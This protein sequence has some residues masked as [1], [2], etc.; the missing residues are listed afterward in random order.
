[1]AHVEDRWKRDGR[2]GTGRRWRVRYAGPDG[3]ERSKSFDRKVDADRFRVAVEADVQRGTYTDPAA[4]KITLR[5]Y[6]AGWQAGYSADTSRGEHIASHLSLHILPTLGEAT[7]GQLAERPSMIRQWYA[8]LPL[9]ALSAG[10]VFITLSA[11]LAAAVDDGKITR[12]PCKAESVRLRTPPRRKIVPWTPAQ[13]AAIRAGMPERWRAIVDCGLGLGLRQGEAFGLRPEAV[14]FL[15]RIVH[16][17]RQVL[18]V[19]GRLWLAAPKEGRERDVPLGEPVAMALAAHMAAFRPREVTL[20]WNEPGS[21]R[22][23]EPVTVRLVFTGPRGQAINSS[24]FGSSW[25]PAR[26][27]A[28]I[29]EG[30]MHMLRH[31]YASV[32]LA[33]GVDI[34][35]LSE[36]LGHHDPGFT[37][38]VYAHL[39]PSAEGRALKAIEAAFCEDHGPE[40]ARDGGNP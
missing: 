10:Q 6:A 21:R 12:N 38:R 33:G 32:L 35:A 29:A 2:R 39:M 13:V 26:G 11:I 36:Y 24:T 19:N 16:V 14:D 22:H 31:A 34:R 1:M 17:N 9:S 20:P 25:R 37:L 27:R 40:T 15:H 4:G 30:G 23:G 28:G 7:L 18:K 8:G 5:R 3:R